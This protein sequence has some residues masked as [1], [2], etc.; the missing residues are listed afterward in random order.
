MGGAVHSDWVRKVVYI[1]ETDYILSCSSSSEQSM[2]PQDRL[3]K[4]KNYIYKVR[5]VWG[6]IKYLISG[7]EMLSLFV[8]SSRVINDY[9]GEKVVQ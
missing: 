9:G 6:Q 1:P 7:S 8:D 2:V 5:K 3:K 4:K